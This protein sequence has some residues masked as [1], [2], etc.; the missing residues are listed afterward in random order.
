VRERFVG[1]V[2]GDFEVSRRTTRWLAIGEDV[3]A[4][5]ADDDAGWKR[6]TAEAWL[7]AKW[8]AAG[9]PAPRV[10][11]EVP[12]RR[13]LV[14]ER[15][16]GLTGDEIHH[17]GPSSRLGALPDVRARL[18]HAPLTRFGERLAES[19]GELAARIRRAVSID[20][21]SHLG[22]SSRHALNLDDVIARLAAKEAAT[23]TRAR[24]WI[25]AL[26][27]PNAVIHGD[28]HFHN[29]CAATDGTITGVFDADDAGIDDAA[30]EFLYI[31]SL[32][33]QF[34]ERAVAAYGEVDLEDVRRAHVRTALGHLLWHGPGTPRHDG[35]V[36]WVS[37]VLE[38]LVP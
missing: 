1:L 35:I 29:M 22:L 34:V 18:D 14:L 33:A 28:L 30:T 24:R 19:Y 2:D 12:D 27:P 37:S 26:P 16:R 6:V 5:A 7:F 17:E 36:A 3:V 10:I 32:G 21:A 8:R 38:R 9:V 31:H 13:V 4:F 23:V 11:A 15:M 20:E 25:E